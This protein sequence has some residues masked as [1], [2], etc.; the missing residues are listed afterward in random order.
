MKFGNVE[1]PAT[2]IDSLKHNRVIVF[3]GAGVS[4]ATPANL[5]DFVTLTRKIL[6]L[7]DN[8]KF[9]NPDQKLGE[10]FDQGVRIHEQ[11][12]RVLNQ[13]SPKP[14]QLHH[15]ILKL[16][17]KKPRVITTNFDLLFEKAFFNLN[18][19]GVIKKFNAPVFPLGSNIEGIIYLHGNV[20]DPS[21]M[22]LSDSDFGRAY[23]SESWAKRLLTDAFLNYD[24]IFIG[25]SYN[26]T[27]LKYLTRSLPKNRAS[28]LYAFAN[29]EDGNTQ[30]VNHWTSLGIE[31]LI[32][33]KENG[34]HLQLPEAVEKISHFLN[35]SFSHYEK[36]ICSKVVEYEQKQFEDALNYVKY[37]LVSDDSYKHFYR[38]ARP[39]VWLLKIKEDQSL[40]DMLMKH[41]GDLFH[42]LSGCL[43]AN[44]NEL[45]DLLQKYPALKNNKNLLWVFFRTL[46]DLQDK[47]CYLKW[48]LFLES[49]LYQE[50]NL[51]NGVHSWVLKKLID[52]NFV[53]EFERALQCYLSIEF[54][55]KLQ[56]T[57]AEY[58]LNQLVIFIK[59]KHQ[60]YNCTL[61]IF[62][63]KL[64]DY[65]KYSQLFCKNDFY[66][67]LEKQEIWEKSD[68]YD[69]LN[70]HLV[71]GVLELFSEKRLTI[72]FR[73]EYAKQC[74]FSESILL[75]R[76]GIYLLNNFSTYNADFIYSLISLSVDWLKIEYR[77]EF[78]NFLEMNY[79]KLSDARKS[80]I[81]VKVK[82]NEEYN[83][84]TKFQWFAW[85]LKNDPDSFIAKK[86]CDL[87][88]SKN[89]NFDL[90]DKPYLSF[91][92]SGVYSVINISPFNVH[93]IQARN[94]YIWYLALL[95]YDFYQHSFNSGNELGYIGLWQEIEKADPKWLLDFIDFSIQV[96]PEHKIIQRV[97]ESSR[98]WIFNELLNDKVFLLFNKIINYAN[99]SQLYSIAEFLRGLYKKDFYKDNHD[100]YVEWLEIAYLVLNRSESDCP[101]VSGDVDIFSKSL[102]SI[103]GSLAWFVIK[104]YEE[105][106]GKKNEKNK[107]EKFIKELLFKDDF[108]HALVWFLK[109]YSF[110][111]NVNSLFAQKEIL[112]LLLTVNEEKKSKA[113]EGFIQNFHL[114]YAEFREIKKEFFN[115]LNHAIDQRND[116]LV[117]ELTELYVYSVYFDYHKNDLEALRKIQ[118]Y[119]SNII[120]ESILS[121]V[122]KI[123][124]K[125]KDIDKIWS[126]LGEYLQ[127]RLYQVNQ[128][129]SK[130][131]ISKIWH[132]LTKHTEF[133]AKAEKIILQLPLEEEWAGFLLDVSRNHADIVLGH[134]VLWCKVLGFY[135]DHQ[136]DR[137]AGLLY[138]NEKNLFRSLIPYDHDEIFQTALTKKG[139]RL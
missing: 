85:I 132:L 12:I 115:V 48:F 43:E 30:Q 113:W 62:L 11:C 75:K 46:D 40:F 58:D 119:E 19:D 41:E 38:L 131:E 23:L 79:K 104:L 97:I 111:K 34:T 92:S 26:D 52:F 83:N 87:I 64:N 42:W 78:F 51:Y 103:N 2:L 73:N 32:Y 122:R 125:E 35:L 128:I 65:E 117:R 29:I 120:A 126:W 112:P 3:A 20:T 107:C 80:E 21:S 90:D 16:F 96:M 9:D 124:S 101:F 99:H 89:S 15:D 70:Y 27:I 139:I 6:N 5:P 130:Q 72:V 135:L 68:S 88:T 8:E 36:F 4:M 109:E 56:F 100:K 95:E 123:L 102:N 69:S 31:P 63:K 39:E 24:F 86:E 91:R 14:T 49:E 106:K 50:N 55:P 108:S 7:D 138:E 82:N 114:E 94:D 118:R 17:P 137:I 28:K 110:M 47:N 129:L 60:F 98:D 1:I 93:E 59:S 71:D 77:A 74:L 67:F 44:T 61:R 134:E 81:I 121:T 136:V 66:T 45:M 53:S 13:N 54:K 84:Y 22:V 33:Q 105:I 116:K 133:I 127:D 37:F 76:A 10:G 18:P 25:Y 57:V